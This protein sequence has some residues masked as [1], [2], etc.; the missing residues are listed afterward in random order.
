MDEELAA[1]LLEQAPD[2]LI[3]AD[4]DGRIQV[5]NPAA[6]RIF[7][8]TSAEAVGQSLD[9]IIPERFRKAQLGGL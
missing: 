2:A 1:V 6:E 7:G 4:L 8:H 5:W 3:F 9:I